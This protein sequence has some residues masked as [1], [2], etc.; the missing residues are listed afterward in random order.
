MNKTSH[1]LGPAYET[2]C[3]LRKYLEEFSFTR[4]SDTEKRLLTDIEL[5]AHAVSAL[6][7]S[8]RNHPFKPTCYAKKAKKAHQELQ[9]APWRNTPVEVQVT[10]LILDFGLESD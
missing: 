8:R 4:F 10:N 7:A 6:A 5:T 3:G 2:L 9:G 1:D